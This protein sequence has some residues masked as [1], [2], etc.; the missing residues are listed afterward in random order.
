[1]WRPGW[2]LGASL[3]KLV[4]QKLQPDESALSRRKGRLVFL[5]TL[6]VQGSALWRLC[7]NGWCRAIHIPKGVTE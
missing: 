2:L 7:A 5:F 1:M 6:R 4:I 3:F